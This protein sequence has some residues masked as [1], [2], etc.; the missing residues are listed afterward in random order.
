MAISLGILMGIVLVTGILFMNLSPQFGGKTTEEER[1][2]YSKS[3]NYKEG[4]FVNSKALK[5]D[6]G[7]SEM[8]KSLLGYFRSQPNTSPKKDLSVLKIDSLDIAEY[9]GATRLLWFGHSTFFVFTKSI[10]S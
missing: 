8:G 1:T 6:M 10:G 7:P 2:A 9:K 5:L 4:K 3:A